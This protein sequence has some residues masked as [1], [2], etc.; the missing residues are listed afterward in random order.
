MVYLI[1]YLIVYLMVY[2]IV[3]LIVISLL[4]NNIR[5]YGIKNRTQ[6]YVYREQRSAVGRHK[7]LKNIYQKRR[8]K[9]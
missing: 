9:F 5:V 7:Y 1:V 4:S 2:L 3:Y 8:Y 6:H